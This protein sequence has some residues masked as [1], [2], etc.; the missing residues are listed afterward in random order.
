MQA[1]VI[2]AFDAP[3]KLQQM[4]TPVLAPTDVLVDVT[5]CGVGLTVVNLLATPGRVKQYPRIPGHEIAGRVTAVG[6][7]VKHLTVGM[8]VTNHFYLTCGLCRHCRSGRETLCLASPGQVGQAIDGGYAQQVAL[9]E[10]NLVPIPDGVS[11][12]DAA[13]GSDAIA[14]PYHACVQEAKVKPGDTVLVV[15]A[16]GGVGIHMIQMARL[17][18]ARVLAADRGDARM[19]FIRTVG[20]YECVDVAQGPMAEQ[21]LAATHG[22][23]VDA[24]IDVV[25]SRSTLEQSL[26]ALAVRGRLVIVGS[27]P[28]GVYGQDPS[29]MVDPQKILHRGLEIHS[30]RYVTLAEI[31]QTLNLIR[32]GQIKPI[33][34]QTVSMREVPELHLSIRHGHTLGRVAML[35]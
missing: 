11:D 22:Q 14:T 34:T 18:G 13:V 20:D 24:V 12:V 27:S 7:A 32:D 31:G 2:A 10:R 19:A 28:A 6:T 30:S 9:P 35:N 15:G 25:G 1:L 23:G 33:V 5:A 4:P 21:V 3:L 29:F 8:R 17:C 26:A 16:A